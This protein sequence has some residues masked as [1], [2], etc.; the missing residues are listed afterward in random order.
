MEILFNIINL[1]DNQASYLINKADKVDQA[2]FIILSQKLGNEYSRNTIYLSL[3]SNFMILLESLYRIFSKYVGS[4]EEY[5]T[6]MN[7]TKLL[8]FAKDFGLLNNKFHQEELSLI[9]TKRCPNKSIDFPGFVDILFK[10][11]KR[12]GDIHDHHDHGKNTSFQTYLDKFVLSQHHHILE[13]QLSPRFAPVTAFGKEYGPENEA[14]RL[15]EGHDDL[16]KHVFT[17]Y[18]SIDIQFSNKSIVTL[19]DFKSFCHDFQV[20]PALVSFTEVHEVFKR[21]QLNEKPILDFRGFVLSLC[22]I[23]NIGNF[24][25]KIF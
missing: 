4:N 16:L 17:L 13:K 10:I 3:L 11:G 1:D 2:T 15:L 9:F 6:K 20:V 25:K 8:A 14:L 24:F 12:T 5:R 19:K 7:F 18:K 21:F 23:A 22:C